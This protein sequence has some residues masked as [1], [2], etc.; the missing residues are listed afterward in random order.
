[1]QKVTSGLVPFYAPVSFKAKRKQATGQLQ[2]FNK[3]ALYALSYHT[4]RIGEE[5]K[6]KEWKSLD[7]EKEKQET[8]DRGNKDIR[9]GEIM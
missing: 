2:G 3:P 6:R 7:V 5:M 4:A 1:M 9:D 8:S